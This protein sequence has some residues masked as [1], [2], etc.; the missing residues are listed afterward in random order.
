MKVNF[1]RSGK[2]MT[3]SGTPDKTGAAEGV[4]D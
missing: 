1:D 4:K 2:L 3:Q